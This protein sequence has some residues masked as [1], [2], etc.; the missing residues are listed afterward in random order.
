MSLIKRIGEFSLGS[1]YSFTGCL[2]LDFVYHTAPAVTKDL[3]SVISLSEGA[4][5]KITSRATMSAA[6]ALETGI[7]VGG[8]LLVYNGIKKCLNS[9]SS[10]N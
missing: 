4:L 2:L 5:E 3:Y 9:L 10:N 1:V 6:L 8:V 7:V